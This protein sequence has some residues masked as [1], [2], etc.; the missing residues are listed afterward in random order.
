VGALAPDA[1]AG[2]VR[3]LYAD[4]ET[5][6]MWTDVRSSAWGA[7]TEILDGTDV[8]AISANV[9]EHSAANGGRKVLGIVFDQE[10]GIAD[11]GAVHYTEIELS[12]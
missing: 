8:M 10:T 11:A 6:D 4:A 3:A 2:A 7:D 1:A 5:H 9:F 12:G